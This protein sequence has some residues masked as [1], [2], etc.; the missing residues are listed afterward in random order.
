MG[1]LGHA[2][3]EHIKH[4][5]LYHR[6]QLGLIYSQPSSEF[7]NIHDPCPF[8]GNSVIGDYYQG[9]SKFK[10]TQSFI[11]AIT[12]K[13]FPKYLENIFHYI[14]VLKNTFMS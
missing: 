2:G 10:E 3:D 4:T 6:I 1:L 11:Q 14:N 9:N 8:Q 12:N 7:Y 5:K 13:S